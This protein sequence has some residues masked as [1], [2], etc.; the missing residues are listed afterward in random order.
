MIAGGEFG[1]AIEP[2]D[3][4]MVEPWYPLSGLSINV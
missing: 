1:K 2:L 4:C 3:M